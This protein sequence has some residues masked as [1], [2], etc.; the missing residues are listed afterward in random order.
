MSEIK[1][2]I[3]TAKLF[4]IVPECVI[5]DAVWYGYQMP[6]TMT[7]QWQRWR[8][9]SP[10]SWLFTQLLFG[11]IS[12]KT[13]KLRVTGLCLGNSPGPVNSPH[14]GP[15]TRKMFPF[16]DV[17]MLPWRDKIHGTTHDHS[18]HHSEIIAD[19]RLSKT[20]WW[21]RNQMLSHIRRLT[22]YKSLVIR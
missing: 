15:I 10:A 4:Y 3:L 21:M 19:K 6:I 13:S 7:S 12:K 5:H 8:L 11:R 17:I 2:E 20:R 14:K 22:K 16:D 18:S 9:K 1:V